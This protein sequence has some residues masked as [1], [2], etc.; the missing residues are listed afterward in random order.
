MA[1]DARV[2]SAP[3]ELTIGKS[4]ELTGW[5]RTEKLDRPRSGPLAHRHRRRAQHGVAAV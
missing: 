4:Y 5:I 3:V 1:R 2:Q